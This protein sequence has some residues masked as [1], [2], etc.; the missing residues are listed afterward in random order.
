MPTIETATT[1][2]LSTAPRRRTFFLTVSFLPRLSEA[3]PLRSP[4]LSQLPYPA[5]AYFLDFLVSLS[6]LYCIS[7]I[8]ARKEDPR[9]HCPVP[10]CRREVLIH[11]G[12]LAPS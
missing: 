1:V 3:P 9:D 10:G 2:E 5:L 4:L 12:R 7:Q 8:R 6:V 11:I